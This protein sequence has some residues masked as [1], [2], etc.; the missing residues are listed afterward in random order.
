MQHFLLGSTKFEQGPVRNYII[1]YLALDDVVILHGNSENLADCAQVNW[2][3]IYLKFRGLVGLKHWLLWKNLNSDDFVEIDSDWQLHVQICE[4][5]G[6]VGWFVE[7]D[8]TKI[9]F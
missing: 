1:S 6:L 8:F 7:D 2:S 4:R 9:E 3:H 5:E